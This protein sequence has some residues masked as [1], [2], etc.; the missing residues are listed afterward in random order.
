MEKWE[1]EVNHEE[2]TQMM[3]W[4]DSDKDNLIDFEDFI[5]IFI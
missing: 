2:V 3:K 1:I 5:K 4:H